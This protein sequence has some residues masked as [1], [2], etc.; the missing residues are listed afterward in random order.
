MKT[1][2]I[3]NND[4]LTVDKAI[5]SQILEDCEY[6]GQRVLD[7]RHALRLA[8]QMEEDG[9]FLEETQLAFGRLAAKLYL[10][11]GRHRLHAVGLSE[12]VVKF[13]AAVYD[14]ATS[15]DLDVLYTKFDTAAKMRTAAHI[16]D[17]LGL[18]DEEGEG[19]RRTMAKL[20]FLAAPLLMI[21]FERMANFQ[22]PV[23]TSIAQKKVEFIRPWKPQGILY[24]TAL[25]RGISKYTTR[26][27]NSG[28]V[29]VGLATLKHH[30]VL[31]RRVLGRRDRSATR[32]TS[33]IRG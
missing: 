6:L 10:V 7:E 25:D 4:L 13:R 32:C 2:S 9:G 22:R 16:I 28:V 15:A 17:A 29:A 31:G 24:Q 23:E 20:M 18:A 27:R 33:A 19:L 11:N 3:K 8:F 14:C 26:F 5:A 21:R 12:K 30:P 1:A